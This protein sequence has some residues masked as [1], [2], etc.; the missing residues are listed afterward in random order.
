MGEEEEGGSSMERIPE[1]CSER[2]DAMRRSRIHL[3]CKNMDRGQIKEG[4]EKKRWSTQGSASGEA[5][6]RGSTD[7]GKPHR[8]G[9]AP[10]AK[11]AGTARG[12]AVIATHSRSP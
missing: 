6:T 9:S 3:Q 1:L 2:R 10:G 11:P 8:R 12:W 4:A 5:R 7:T